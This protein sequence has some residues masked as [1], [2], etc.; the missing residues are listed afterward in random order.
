MTLHIVY[1]CNLKNIKIMK[2]LLLILI[3]IILSL[4]AVAQKIIQPYVKLKSGEVKE[5]DKIREGLF[6]KMV[7]T[8][9]NK[10]TTKFKPKELNSVLT[11]KIEEY[12]ALH[13][14]QFVYFRLKPDKCFSK[15][16]SKLEGKSCYKVIISNGTNMIVLQIV[17][18]N[19]PPPTTINH[20]NNTNTPQFKYYYI[21]GSNYTYISE[22]DLEKD[23]L[24]DDMIAD[25]SSCEGVTNLLTEFKEKRAKYLRKLLFFNELK[26][27]YYKSCLVL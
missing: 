4:S 22:Y 3:T 9:S 14:N 10:T 17:Q 25:F 19:T 15:T 24:I 1:L 20:V 26:K 2:T 7:A 8:D 18:R 11:G 6:K 27:L 16:G 23:E 12:D 21:K 13:N 5:F